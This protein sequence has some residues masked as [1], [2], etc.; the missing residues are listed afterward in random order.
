MKYR[1]SLL[2]DEI[3]LIIQCIAVKI[4][5]RCEIDFEQLGCDKNHIQI[6]LLCSFQPKYSISEIIRR[7]KSITARE[8]FEVFI[9]K[10]K[11]AGWGVLV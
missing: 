4:G 11:V 9:V 2:S 6:L 7:F 1:K 5:E 3:T 8:L 10:E